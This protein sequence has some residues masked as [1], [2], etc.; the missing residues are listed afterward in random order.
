[1]NGDL[2]KTRVTSLKELKQLAAEAAER[3]AKATAQQA[4]AEA[5][6]LASLRKTAAASWLFE[7][8]V[9]KVMPLKSSPRAEHPK[10]P[11]EPF[12]VQRELDEQAVLREALSDGFDV[13]TLLD[14]DET[15]SFCR[16]GLGP[17]VARRLRRGDWSIQRQLDLHG[18]RRDDARD[19]LSTFIREAHK[20][21]LRCVRVVHGKGLGSPGKTPVLKSRVQ[22][23]LVQKDEVLAFVQARPADGGAGALLVLLKPGAARQ[24]RGL[25]RS[26]S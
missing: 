22:S 12:A 16:A 20:A 25:L 17:D 11:P 26:A 7:A 1:M 23:W 10:R 6:Q 15:L 3:S 8:A 14:T 21:G 9:G 13:S 18:L 5:A 4:A 2:R 24:A 19:R